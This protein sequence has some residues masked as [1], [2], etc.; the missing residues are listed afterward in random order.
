VYN[1]IMAKE[2]IYKDPVCGM[3]INEE[4][5]AGRYKY[6]GT[7]YYF[8]RPNCLERFKANPEKFLTKGESPIPMRKFSKD[9]CGLT[10][11]FALG[12]TEITTLSISGMSCAS[13]ALT[14][15]NAVKNLPGVVSITVNFAAEKTVIEHDEKITPVAK[16][17]KAI[18]DVGYEIRE[19][20]GDR[21][22]KVQI[23]G[24]KARIRLYLVWGFTIPIIALM[25]LE[26]VFIVHIPDIDYLMIILGGLAV[27][28]TGFRTLKAGVNALRHKSPSMDVLIG[29]GCLTAFLSGALRVLSLPVANYSGIAGM[30]MAFHITGRYV[31]TMA[32]GR[33]SQA[34]KKLLKLGAKRA[35]VLI[36]N[37]E[38]EMPI[39]EVKVSDILIVK[40]GEKIPTD[41]EILSGISTVDESMVTGESLPVEKKEGNKVIGATVNQSGLLRIRATKVGRDTFLAQII[42]LVEASQGSK[43]PIQEFVDR[44]TA[45]FVPVILLISLLTFILWLLF[46]SELKGILITVSSFIPWVNPNLDNLS[47]AIFAAVAVLVIACPCALGLATPTALM[48]GLG[49]GAER[50]ILFRC[51]EAIQTMKEIKVIVFDKTGTITKGRPEVTDII[52]EANFEE[53]EVLKYAASVESGSGHPLAGAIVESAKVRDILLVMPEDLITIPGKGVKAK[54]EGKEVLVGSRRLL[55]DYRI[56]YQAKEKEI[57]G[58][59]NEAKTTILV[60]VDGKF[61]GIIGVADPLKIDSSSAIKSLKDMGL[62]LI[63]ITGDN[64]RTG[65]AVANKVGIDEVMTNVLPQDKQKIVKKLQE[66]YGMVAMVGDGINDAPALTQANVGIA[67]GTGTDIAIESSDIVLVR[68]DLSAVS[69]A[70]KLSRAT[71]VKIKQNLFWAFFYN[72]IALPIAILGLLHPVIAEIAM[73]MSS[74][75]VVTNANRLRRQKL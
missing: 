42:K 19:E 17:K 18:T 60:A 24:R 68:G 50:G 14:I 43:V 39:E 72:V 59:E 33:A 4:E 69:T 15:E 10:P 27:F 6:Q 51:G 70:V 1:I 45:K 37:Q 31:E 34:I 46:S 57:S 75:N 56:S 62:K 49:R 32:K 67:I 3:E 63:M 22:D 55:D 48:V 41:G 36:D 12:K 47:L 53:N 13:C 66:R 74:I 26:M 64:D 5:A 29:I 71:F 25:L 11:R 2:K 28:V 52:T 7:V 73:A 20:I 21:E 61:V 65:K 8:C 38:K 16:I 44:V 35:R 9:K 30:I 40:P 54:V 58:L 23:E